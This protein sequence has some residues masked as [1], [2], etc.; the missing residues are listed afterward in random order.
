MNGLTPRQK[1][2]LSFIRS[3]QAAHGW[4]PTVREIAAGVGGMGV[5]AA[6]VNLSLIAKKGYV[7]LGGGAREICVLR[8]LRGQRVRG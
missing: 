5:R 6:W 7:R 4:A 1:Q 3:H 2:V 8:G